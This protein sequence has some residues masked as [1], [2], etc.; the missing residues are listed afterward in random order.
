VEALVRWQH[1][2]HGLLAPS[3]FIPLAE[4]TGLIVDLGRSILDK[5]CR[6]ATRWRGGAELMLGVNLSARQLT[7][8]GLLDQVVATLS[9][10][11]LPAERLVLEITETALLT[12]APDRVLAGL[13][14]MGIR[15]ALDDFGTGYSSLEHLR[16][17]PVDSIKI[18]K[19]F[20]GRVTGGRSCSSDRRWGWQ[21]WPKASR[22]PSRPPS[23]A[24]WAAATARATT[25]PSR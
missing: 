8:P 24:N 22:P 11:G 14:Q 19:V 20:I 15:I 18:D 9:S 10:T 25:S 6:Q 23:C 3:G 17:F 5:A 2:T 7:D 13:R 21:R 16:R 12:S 1:P 4:T